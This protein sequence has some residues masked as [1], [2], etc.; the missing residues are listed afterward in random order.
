MLPVWVVAKEA[1]EHQKQVALAAQKARE[2]ELQE[3]R[4]EMRKEAGLSK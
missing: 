1:E 4:E 3:R 2:K